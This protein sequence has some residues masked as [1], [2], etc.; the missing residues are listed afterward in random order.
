MSKAASSFRLPRCLEQSLR[1]CHLQRRPLTSYRNAEFTTTTR[2]W[3]FRARKRW[4]LM[5]LQTVNKSISFPMETNLPYLK[6]TD[7]TATKR[8]SNRKFSYK[9]L[10]TRFSTHWRSHMARNSRSSKTRRFLLL[11]LVT[12]M[13]STSLKVNQALRVTCRRLCRPKSLRPSCRHHWSWLTLSLAR[14]NLPGRLAW[15]SITLGLKLSLQSSNLASC[16]KIVQ[17]F[18]QIK[19]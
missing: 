3:I 4:S 10:Q 5:W 6:L 15:I 18:C 19:D 14:L 13:P 12:S 1:Q 7:P 17:P 8:N 11:N 9:R 16:T 2:A